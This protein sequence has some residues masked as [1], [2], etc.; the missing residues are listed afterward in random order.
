MIGGF[1]LVFDLLLT[2]DCIQNFLKIHMDFECL[3][4]YY[5]G[6]NFCQNLE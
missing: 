2:P 3:N 4:L 5:F 6:D 1:G